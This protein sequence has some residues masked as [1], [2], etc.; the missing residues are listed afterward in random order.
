MTNWY[1][2]VKT[3]GISVWLD[4]VRPMPAGYNIHAKTAKEAIDLL[5]NGD[6][7]RI[8][9]DHDLG[10]PANGTGMDV[11]KFIEKQAFEGKIKPPRASLHTSNPV[12]RANM[13]Q[14]IRNAY[15]Y[16]ERHERKQTEQEG[17]DGLV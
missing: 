6:V 2:M 8:S 17:K 9:L 12:G 7:D 1:S 15:E 5:S 3:A 4:D 10:E 11:A 14:A 16:W 13:A